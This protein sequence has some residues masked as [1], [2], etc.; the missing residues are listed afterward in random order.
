MFSQETCIREQGVV[1]FVV[2][3]KGRSFFWEGE[4]DRREEEGKAWGGLSPR[5]GMGIAQADNKENARTQTARF[6]WTFD[7]KLYP[8]E[9]GNRREQTARKEERQKMEAAKNEGG[10]KA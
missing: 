6:T 2:V 4:L 10:K 5:I 9:K 1:L 3:F 8:E 7:T